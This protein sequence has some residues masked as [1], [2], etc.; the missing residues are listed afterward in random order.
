M[1]NLRLDDFTKYKFLSGVKISPDGEN[2]GFVVHEMD[3]DNNKYLSNI[4]IY[5][6][7]DKSSFQLSSSN[8]ETQ[9]IWIDNNTILFPSTRN[10]KDKE[11][12]EKGEEFTGFYEISINGGEAKKSFEIPLNINNLEF[13][14]KN[15]LVF[16]GLY[17]LNKIDMAL[18]NLL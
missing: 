1:E 9:F 11:R 4:H 7:K 13:I 6:E 15:T 3:V 10:K 5:N 14:D 2:T 12:K 17:D 8:K 18:I 16:T